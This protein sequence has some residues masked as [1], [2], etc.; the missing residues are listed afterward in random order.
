MALL[1]HYLPVTKSAVCQV[2]LYPLDNRLFIFTLQSAKYWLNDKVKKLCS[3]TQINF[4]AWLLQTYYDTVGSGP[5]LNKR[6]SENNSLYLSWE[7]RQS[8]P[9]DKN[10]SIR[11]SPI[12][13][14]VNGLLFQGFWS[15]CELSK[16]EDGWYY[17]QVIQNGG[18]NAWIQNRWWTIFEL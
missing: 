12:E 11:V 2:W 1:I 5:R 7:Q 14:A 18:F 13:T 8:C 15:R 9:W 16:R 4:A 17:T 10:N 3:F 6:V